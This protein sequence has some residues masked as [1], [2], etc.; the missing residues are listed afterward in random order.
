MNFLG[1]NMNFGGSTRGFFA[2]GNYL[3]D[4]ENDVF[5]RGKILNSGCFGVSRNSDFLIFLP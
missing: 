1:K 4:A 5:L 3:F 2:P